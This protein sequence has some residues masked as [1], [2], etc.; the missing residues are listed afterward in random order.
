[1]ARTTGISCTTL[2]SCMSIHLF[3]QSKKAG[4]LTCIFLIWSHD[5]YRMI[6]KFNFEFPAVQVVRADNI[7]PSK[8]TMLSSGNLQRV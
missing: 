2:I 4:I 6:T 1:M 7:P 3:S 5:I 8:L